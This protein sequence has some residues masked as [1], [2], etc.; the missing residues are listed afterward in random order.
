LPEPASIDT[1]D[2]WARARRRLRDLRGRDLFLATGLLVVVLVPFA[3]ALVRAVRDGWVPSGDEANIVTRAYDVFSRHPPLTGLASTSRL[4]GDK[5]S[6][7]HPGPIEFYLIAVPLRVLGNSAGPLLTAAAI[8]ATFA[9]IALWVFFRRLGLTAM[10]WAG[11]MMLAVLWSGGTSV[12]TDTLSSNMTM[13]A[14]LCTA[15]LAWALVDGDLRLLP[16]AAVVASYTAQQHLAAG[17]IVV[18]L[19]VA[20]VIALAVQIVPRVRRG[21]TSIAKVTLRWSGA[22]LVVSAVCWAPVAIDEVKDHPGNL[23]EIVRFARDNTRPTLGF[24]SGV[25]QALHAITPP[26]I[27]GRTDTQGYFFLPHAS[28]SSYAVGFLIVA[29]LAAIVWTARARTPSL[30][31]LAIV[32]LV[33]LVAGVI[34]GGNVPASIEVFRVNLYRWT[35]AAAF[36]T[37]TTIGIALVFL[38]DAAFGGRSLA[39]PVQRFGPRFAAPALLVVAALIATTTVFVGGRDDHNREAPGFA[40]EKRVAAIVLSRLDRRHPVVVV[41]H[42]FA[43]GLSVGPYVILRLVEAGVQV[44]VPATLNTTYGNA[45]VYRP[46]SDPY[47]LI[48][49]SAPTKPGTEPGA[50]IANQFFSAERSRLLD[51][52]AAAAGGRKVELAPGARELIDRT[53]K[54]RLRTYVD[55]LLTRFPTDPRAVLAQPTFLTFIATGMISLP[56]LDKKEAQRLLELPADQNTISGDEQVQIHVLTSDELHTVRLPGL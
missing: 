24:K 47:A 52:L 36:M 9:L 44:E 39:R 31:R 51:E 55:G 27:L 19:T 25:Y 2:G 7:N 37:W 34:N 38:A 33:L 22:A 53:Y 49:S 43:A 54:G 41:T 42:G 56:T 4:Y 12:L 46:D 48:I 29:A 10:L 11:V 18:V 50:L 20:V 40:L 23:T 32:A 5:I 16:L 15:V 30:S 6:A 26:T 3:V 45:R 1:D 35:W 17:L 13:Y 28:A 8:N 21:D 14:L